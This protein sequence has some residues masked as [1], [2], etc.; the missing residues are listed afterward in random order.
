MAGGGFS[1]LPQLV[2]RQRGEDINCRKT[3]AYLIFGSNRA[4][5]HGAFEIDR[6]RWER[7][8][9]A[10]AAQCVPDA[11]ANQSI[12]VVILRVIIQPVFYFPI[13]G[14]IAELPDA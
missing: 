14:R 2:R 8:G 13:D 11:L 1:Q 12:G 7:E 4:R 6:A 9:Q 3:V 10:T 5:R